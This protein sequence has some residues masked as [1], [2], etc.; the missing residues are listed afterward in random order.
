MWQRWHL[1]W[2]VPITAA[3]TAL[4]IWVAVPDD[5]KKPIQDA[6][7]A[8][9]AAPPAAQ[10]QLAEQSQPVA[11]SDPAAAPADAVARSAPR[12]RSEPLAGRDSDD[13]LRAQAEKRELRQE[14]E[15]DLQGFARE[16]APAA[17]PAAAT[18]TAPPATPTQAPLADVAT[19]RQVAF[20]PAEVV[21]PDPAI[22]WRVMP[23]GQ[24]ERS[25][26]AGQT[27]EAVALPQKVTAVRA[28]SATTAIATAADGRQFRTDD[29]GKT[30][31]PV[32]P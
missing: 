28:L 26:N 31:N 32:Q 13:S 12:E 30:W 19:A 22:R 10:S 27:W 23:T 11:K 20:P 17:A 9:D 18:A 7:I 5:R 6:F 4:A 24:L 2:A 16:S 15:A 29:Q 1:R 21:S 14:K 8:S 25:T 3:A